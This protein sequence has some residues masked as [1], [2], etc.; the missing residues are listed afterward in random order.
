VIETLL[1]PTPMMPERLTGSVFVATRYVTFPSPCPLADVVSDIHDACDDALH[2][3]S[4]ST[5]M[6]T[7]PTPPAESKD[8]GDVDAAVSHRPEAVGD[9]AATLVVAELPQAAVSKRSDAVVSPAIKLGRARVNRDEQDMTTR[10]IR[11]LQ[12]PCRKVASLSAQG[13]VQ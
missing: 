7:V 10:R 9:G 4:R 12:L 13:V 8:D 11:S 2:V 1:S 5:T 6:E 3:Q